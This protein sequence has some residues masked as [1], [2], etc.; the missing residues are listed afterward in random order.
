MSKPTTTTMTPGDWLHR[1]LSHHRA[2]TTPGTQYPGHRLML[3][4]TGYTRV[5]DTGDPLQRV[6]AARGLAALA[7]RDREAAAAQ[8]YL[9]IAASIEVTGRRVASPFGDR[10]GL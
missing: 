7:L 6:Q 4:V 8:R 5:L 9:E 10:D 1:A 3:A 2:G